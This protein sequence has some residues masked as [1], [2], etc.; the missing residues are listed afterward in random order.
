M[1]GNVWEFPGDS[2]EAKIIDWPIL[3]NISSGL[4]RKNPVQVSTGA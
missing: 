3:V 2:V 1:A 4:T